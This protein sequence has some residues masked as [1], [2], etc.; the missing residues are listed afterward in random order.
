MRGKEGDLRK[1]EQLIILVHVVDAANER[2][3]SK[4]EALESL[5]GKGT[6]IVSQHIQSVLDRL[7]AILATWGGQVEVMIQE[8]KGILRI[9]D[10][11]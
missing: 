7:T 6:Q 9:L 10:P 11:R 3:L 1:L 2:R 8:S 4:L 5:D